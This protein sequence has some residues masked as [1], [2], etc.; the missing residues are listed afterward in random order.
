VSL[1]MSTNDMDPNIRLS[2][3]RCCGADGNTRK[4]IIQRSAKTEFLLQN[5][6][7]RVTISPISYWTQNISR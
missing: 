3:S 6:R 2:G 7:E 4:D 5:I 1:R